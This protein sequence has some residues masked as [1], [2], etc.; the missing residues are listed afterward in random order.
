MIEEAPR[1]S[2][3]R[4][5]VVSVDTGKPVYGW[6]PGDRVETDLIG[7]LCSRVQSKGVGVFKS[8]KKVLEAT[9]QALAELLMDLKGRV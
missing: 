5:Q 1:R 4:I 6:Q 2:A 3:Y 7:E 8:E 9:R